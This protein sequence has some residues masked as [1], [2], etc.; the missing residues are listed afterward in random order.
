MPTVVVRL[1]TDAGTDHER[2]EQRRQRQ[3]NLRAPHR[4]PQQQPATVD[5][6][7]LVAQVPLVNVAQADALMIAQATVTTHHRCRK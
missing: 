4:V 6:A 3:Q 7:L 5:L 1:R 2:A